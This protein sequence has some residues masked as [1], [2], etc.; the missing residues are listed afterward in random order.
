MR[1]GSNGE[2][3]FNMGLLKLRS[4]EYSESSRYMAEA[5]RRGFSSSSTEPLDI[6]P[7]TN[8]LYRILL[9]EKLDFFGTI[10][11]IFF[12]ASLAIF[13]LSF[14]PYRFPPPF[15]CTTCGRA[16]CRK[17][18]EAEADEVICKECFAKLKTTENVE[19]EQL[20]RHSVGNRHLRMKRTIAYLINAIVPGAGLIYLN[21]N[22]AGV[23]VVYVVMLAYAPLLLPQFF[24]KPAGWVSLQL[25]SIFVVIAV[26]VAF[27][28]YVYTFLAIRGA[29]GD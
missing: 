9:S 11:P 14:L 23:F 12:F 29:H 15:Y 6:M 3:F 19:M 16:I 27:F 2:P 7:S 5:R 18:Q 24:V 26:V 28:A 22:L 17:C 25:T 13:V 10:N 8:E 1:A 4:L 20:L 21:R